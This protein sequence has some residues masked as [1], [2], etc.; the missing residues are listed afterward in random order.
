MQ[1]NATMGLTPVTLVE[2]ADPFAAIVF[3]QWGVL[4]N[5]SAPYRGAVEAIQAL[6]A[7]GK[8]LAVLS[9]SGKRAAPNAQRIADMGLP[10]EL[11]TQV[12][13]SG[14]AF[15]KDCQS[16][17]VAPGRLF[18][19]T[20]KP[21]DFEA[22]RHG[23][24]L[25]KADSIHGASAVLLMGLPEGSDG[26]NQKLVLDEARAH[27]LPL[28]CTNPDRGSPRANGVVQ[29]SPGALADAYRQAG[30]DV[31]FYGKPHRPIFDA[32][33]DALAIPPSQT[34]MVGDS[35]E[36]DIAGGAAA[37]WSTAFVMG[38]LH[39][40]AFKG[41]EPDTATRRLAAAHNAPLPTFLISQ[42]AEIG[43]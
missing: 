23:L 17:R 10:V 24:G 40:D 37:G 13:T 6:A 16:G 31:T 29:L 25:A 4:H 14:E 18:P 21:C 5:G 41:V 9:N 1:Q 20:A 42:L 34:L 19:I 12:M 2:C 33:T 3:D 15:W 8:V 7:K 35:L 27:G 30:G 38:G 43:A 36:H 28:Y 32:L 22:W 39:V 11:F 26:S